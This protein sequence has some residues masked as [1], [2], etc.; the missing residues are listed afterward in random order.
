MLDQRLKNVI[1]QIKEEFDVSL[2]NTSI[3]EVVDPAPILRFMVNTAMNW[4]HKDYDTWAIGK[5]LQMKMG[6]QKIPYRA[7]LEVSAGLWHLINTG[8]V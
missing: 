1:K 2:K 8:K 4:S 7:E 5:Q 6:P 3:E